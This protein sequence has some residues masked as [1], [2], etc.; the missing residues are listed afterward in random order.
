VVLL[1]GAYSAQPE[2][3]DLIDVAVLMTLDDTERG[4][5]LAVRE[6]SEYMR[7]WHELWD[8]AEDHYFSHV[9]PPSSFD[10]VLHSS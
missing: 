5:R 6:G 7:R 4:R 1:D 10:I 3:S 8:P 9:R 2:L